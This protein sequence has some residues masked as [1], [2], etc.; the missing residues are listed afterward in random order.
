MAISSAGI[1]SGLDVNSIVSQLMAVERRPLTL[2]QNK[3]T[4]Y[5]AQVS[6]YGTLSSALSSFQ[7]AMNGLG[8]LE[9]FKVYS[10]T[11]SDTT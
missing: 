10:A 2:L 5:N 7:S 3:E 1:G 11:S 6:S 9:K 4:K 8:D